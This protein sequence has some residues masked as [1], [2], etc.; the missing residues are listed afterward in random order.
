M[1]LFCYRPGAIGDTVLTAPALAWL[2]RR[3]PDAALTL[4]IRPD[5]HEVFRASG[6]AAAVVSP[7]DLRFAPYFASDAPELDFS[8]SFGFRPDRA[9]VWMNRAAEFCENLVRSGVPQI[10]VARARPSADSARSAAEVFCEF[11]SAADPLT[12]LE[13]ARPGPDFFQRSLLC[14]APRAVAAAA[15]WLSERN[16]NRAAPLLVLHAGAGG[17]AKQLPA[18]VSAALLRDWSANGGECC[19]SAGPADEAALAALAAELAPDWPETELERRTAR[20]SLADLAG[21]LTLAFAAVGADSGPLHLAASLG[22]RT[23]VFFRASNPVVWR[24]CGLRAVAIDC[25]EF[26]DQQSFLDRARVGLRALE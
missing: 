14:A 23:L 16:L 19:V 7:E 22:A 6:L 26:H 13:T 24:P 5:L 10:D 15:A 9:F 11:S 3:F 2:G 25:R 12:D 18:A 17:V 21:L 8:H 1:R 20:L 4:A